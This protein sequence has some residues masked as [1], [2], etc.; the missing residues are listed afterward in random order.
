MKKQL[1][2][3]LLFT[4]VLSQCLAQTTVFINPVQDNSIYSGFTANSNGIGPS[5]FSATP[6]SGNPNRALLQFDI[7]GNV[8]ATA[9]ITNA[10][11][12]LNCEARGGASA[13][14]NH[15]IHVVITPWGEGPSLGGGAG[16]GGGV[17][18]IP[19]DAT[20]LFGILGGVPWITPGGDF[21]P[22]PSATTLVGPPGPYIWTGANMVA[23]V[24][25][26]LVSPAINY[27]WLLKIDI[28]GI[29]GTSSRWTSR[30][31]TPALIPALAVTY[32]D[33]LNIE[34]DVLNAIRVYPNPTRGHVNIALNEEFKLE[35]LRIL[36][37]LGQVLLEMPGEQSDFMTLDLSSLQS[38][39]YL[40]EINSGRGSMRK[41][42]VRK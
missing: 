41:R 32:T 17:P 3:S 5:L 21:I 8:P 24:Q 6:G 30:E 35:N 40:L 12:T 37:L 9:T 2:T 7:A 29:P 14:E 4:F 13:G 10:V 34:D 16:G 1:L 25:T 36:N 22:V 31:G 15:S 18:A 28:E 38:G 11:L 39:I 19:P 27:G 26:W 23:D 33:T 42:I 20:W